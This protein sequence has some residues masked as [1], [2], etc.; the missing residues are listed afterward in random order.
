MVSSFNYQRK[1]LIGMT[2]VLL[3]GS[4]ICFGSTESIRINVG[5]GEFTDENNQ[6]WLKDFGYNTGRAA[7]SSEPIANT[8]NDFLYQTQR[9]DPRNTLEMLYQI[10]VANGEYN[11]KLHL[12][13]TWDGAFGK[14]LRTFDVSAEGEI[15]VEGIDIFDA[16]GANSPLVITIPNVVINDEQLDLEFFHRAQ[17]PTLAG[18]EIT[19]VPQPELS[20]TQVEQVVLR[21]N[22][23][24]AGFYDSKDQY[25][26]A[27]YGFNTGKKDS[28]TTAVAGTAD[29]VLF[30]EQHR[31]YPG[32]QDLEYRFP[33]VDGN[34][35]VRLYF[36]ENYAPLHVV[37]GRVFH[38]EV[39]GSQRISDLDIFAEAGP[40]TALM[41]E[42]D[43]VQVADGE[44]N[45]RFPRVKENPSLAAIEV[46]AVDSLVEP[47]EIVIARI[48]AGGDAFTDADGNEWEADRNFNTG[49]IAIDGLT[50]AVAE[51]ELD[52]IYNTQR[53][54]RPTNSELKYSFPVGN[55]E[56]RVRL[57]F[58]ENYS[59]AYGADIRV[60]D[61]YAE[62]QGQLYGVDIFS[63]AG[64][65]RTAVVST[66]EDI[67]VTD[68]TLDLEFIHVKQ[69]PTVAGIEIIQISSLEDSDLE[70]SNNPEP[71]GSSGSTGDDSGAEQPT[72]DA[73]T[74]SD[75]PASEQPAVEQP[76]TEEPDSS[77]SSALVLLGI[78][79]QPVASNV[80]AGETASFS[81]AAKSNMAIAYQWYHNGV[82]IPGATSDTLTITAA[83]KADR[84]TYYCVVQSLSTQIESKAV[85]LTVNLTFDVAISWKA[86]AEREDGSALQAS[87]IQSYEL[88]YAADADQ[89]LTLVGSVSKDNLEYVM[90]E[91]KEG[92]H[93]F[94][95]ATV[96]SD[97]KRSELSERIAK[98][99]E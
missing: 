7:S 75:E 12:A 94:A 41:K 33:M 9:Y 54:D 35:K 91:L 55:G 15:S 38:V 99:F 50:D 31:D 88:Y 37:G 16:V 73:P 20:N 67:T 28:F 4:N 27:D 29:D 70:Y 98:T 58:S 48:N 83:D 95:M 40:S 65:E 87:D 69:N 79:E 26:E 81:V 5:G 11:I 21:V 13:E 56:Y 60:F 90:N 44:L 71:N 82:A 18:I 49:V 6:T 39:E 57:H 19:P 85:D 74:M 77:G 78:T 17:N 14:G 63:L 66:I 80:E 86:P 92:T 24:G 2:S 23:G 97:G 25:W 89:P 30:K 3:V 96:D 53:W 68:G 59:G 51:T 61:V 72:I 62:D 93:Y 47:E 43:G 46:V 36:S 84:G 34:Y 32:G 42:I 1:L 64:A 52:P 8:K 45:I 22:A 10:P 76:A